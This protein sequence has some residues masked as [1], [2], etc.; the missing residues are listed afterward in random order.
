MIRNVIRNIS[1][2]LAPV[3]KQ[4][5][6][7]I[8]TVTILNN[9]I[10]KINH[11]QN[12]KQQFYKYRIAT[13]SS[14][15]N[16]LNINNKRSASFNALPSSNEILQL[17]EIMK[18]GEVINVRGCLDLDPRERITKKE[19]IQ[20]CEKCGINEKN[21]LELLNKLHDLGIVFYFPDNRNT[22]DFV[23]IKP[24]KAIQAV[25]SSFG[26]DKLYEDEIKDKIQQLIVALKPLE[27]IKSQ[28]DIKANRYGNMTIW[29][30]MGFPV[31]QFVVLARAVW[32]EYSWDVIEPMTYFINLGNIIFWLFIFNITKSEFSYQSLRA[33]FVQKRAV[34]L[35]M[36]NNF[37]IQKFESLQSTKQKLEKELLDI[38]E[39]KNVYT[40]PFIRMELHKSES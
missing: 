18:K 29:S 28:L 24:Q 33:R 30:L 2:V 35:Y 36:K 20:I 34:K 19:Y 10:I 4:L 26:M 13:S 27:E 1:Q 6:T 37:D 22:H 9:R 38:K 32:W 31:A 5:H 12:A 40:G 16:C 11:I 3:K 14:M 8:S 7:Q 21:A 23:M 25:Y 17:Q 15:V 39:Y